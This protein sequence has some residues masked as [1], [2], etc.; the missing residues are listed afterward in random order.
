[1]KKVIEGKALGYLKSSLF[2]ILIYLLMLSIS[3]GMGKSAY[4]KASAFDYI[5]SSSVLTVI[6]AYAIAIP[7]S[8]GRW[9]FAAGSISILSGIIGCTIG[10]K[11]GQSLA[12][13][14]FATIAVAV[15][16]SLIEGIV[17]IFL[18][19]STTIVSLGIV[20]IYEAL[21]SVVFDGEG[22]SLVKYKNMTILDS[23]PWCYILLAV[24]IVMIWFLLYHTRFG[25]N[26]Q[27]L[28]NNA[29]IAIASGI[30]QKK[31]ILLTYLVVGVLL[32]ICGVLNA[33]SANVVPVSNLSSTDIMY[34][35]MGPVLIGLFLGQ[36][37][38]MPWGILMGSIGMNALSYGMVVL[39][40][41]GSIQQILTGVFIVFFMAYSA[42]RDIFK[43][44]ILWKNLFAIKKEA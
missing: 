26:S 40:L 27:S 30:D 18:R 23:S 8:G 16:L 21:T 44:M 42:N 31:N 12:L 33:S 4:Y 39:G 43:K 24:V 11:Y 36:F 13:A 34:S 14:L 29:G 41:E 15:T 37:S 5:F 1:M 17:Y 3:L 35:S 28:G 25:L 32:G 9:D 2:P 6:M 19:V 7:L 22:V 10:I 20:M 38:D